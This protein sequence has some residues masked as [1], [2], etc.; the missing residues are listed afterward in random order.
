MIIKLQSTDHFGKGKVGEL[1]VGRHGHRSR[2]DQVCVMACEWREKVWREA[3]GM[4][5]A[6]EEI[7]EG[8]PNEGSY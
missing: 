7:Y 1:E 3:A 4:G 2:R 5:E 6:L 8:D